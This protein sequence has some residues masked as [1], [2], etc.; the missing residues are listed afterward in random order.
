MSKIRSKE[1]NANKQK[2]I[3]TLRTSKVFAD[4]F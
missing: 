1:M 2:I 4:T 3:T